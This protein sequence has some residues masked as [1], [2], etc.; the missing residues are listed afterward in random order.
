MRAL[1]FWKRLGRAVRG[2]YFIVGA[3][4][5]AFLV[6]VAV[7]GPE[8]APHNP[9]LVKRLQWIDGELHKAP[10]PPS[11]HYR[12]GTDNLGRDQLSLLLYGARTTLVMAFAATIARMLLGLVLGTCAGWWPGS[13]FDR[14][15][16]AITDFLA[17]IPGLI[18]AMLLVFA[19]G[20]HRGQ[21]AFVVA[22]S[23]VGWG[24]IA[25]IVR[26]HVL[27]IRKKLYIMAARSLGLSPIGVLSRHV[28]PNLL[29]TFLALAALEM[30]GVLLLLGELGFVNVFVGGGRVGFEMG[31]YETRHYFDVPDWGAMLG[32]SWRWFRSYPWYPLVPAAAF[33]VSILGFN[34]FGYGLQRFVERGRFHPS[35][36][37]VLRFLL[38]VA[39]ALLGARALLRSSGIEAQFAK[40]VRRFDA[41]RAWEDVAYLARP[42]L[43][44]RPAG[45]AA[46]AEAAGYIASQFKRAGLTP[47]TREGSYFQHY[48][49]VRGQVTAEPT[50]EV[51]GADGESELVLSDGVSFDPLQAFEAVGSTEAGLVLANK[52]DRGTVHGLEGAGLLLLDP[53][54]DVYLPWTGTMPYGAIL[55]IV[56]DTD[57][58][59]GDQAPVFDLNAYGSIERLPRFANLLVG[60]SAARELL[61]QVDL[62]LEELQAEV[63]AGKDVELR[64]GLRIRLTYGLTYEEVSAINVVGY[65]PGLDRESQ[66]ERVLLGATY[67]GPPPK[68]GTFCPGADE[69]A[70]GVATLLETAR[71]FGDLDLVPKRTVV[72]AAF[73]ELGGSRFVN[74]PVLPTRP[75]NT[76][77][78]VVLHGLGAGGPRLGRLE[79]GSGFAR[80]FD[81]SAR[82]FGVRTQKLDGWQFFFVSSYSRLAWGEPTVPK[83]Y[84]GLV[85]TRPGDSL[86]GT[87]ADTLGHLESEL[88]AEAGRAVAHYVMVV[89]AR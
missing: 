47:I 63:E 78:T 45:S 32:T 1:T 50:L 58:A 56:P 28:L 38:V 70:S 60:E 24:E 69:N 7:L 18:L 33:F 14:A 30:G 6:L 11:D 26:G 85:V 9:Y 75:S 42:E 19:V 62:D 74:S 31:T 37:S 82:R 15:I 25:Q 84:Q 46:A 77:T 4:L 67:T 21:I 55:R 53:G 86:S 12:L 64:T 27:T 54:A 10:F 87:P 35:G 59:S 34:L 49:A 88:L 40:Q 3:V 16:S 76:W 13:L 73:G 66:G 17:A 81:Q 80:A 51:L 65:I 68:D 83:S 29:A 2:S 43:K 20:I 22:L 52:A 41:A 23:L 44:G 8:L 36:W 5:V 89:S 39:L 71:L 79:E 57:L 48:T 61:A 72:F